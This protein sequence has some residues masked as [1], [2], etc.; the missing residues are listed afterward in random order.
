MR[1]EIDK[2][3]CAGHGRCNAVAPA[4]FTLDDE[5]HVATSSFDAT[6]EQED[7]AEFAADSCPESVITIVY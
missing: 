4:L 6:P 3:K 1:V 5:G 2:G 7:D